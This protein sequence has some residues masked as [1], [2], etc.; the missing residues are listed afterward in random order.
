MTKKLKFNLNS[1][2]QLQ[3]TSSPRA[4]TF[5]SKLDQTVVVLGL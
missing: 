4:W 1:L 2:L 3:V 5:K